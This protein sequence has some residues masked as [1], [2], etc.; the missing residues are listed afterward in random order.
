[1]DLMNTTG[2]RIHHFGRKSVVVPPAVSYQ[3]W[4]ETKSAWLCRF[5]TLSQLL[6][7]VLRIQGLPLLVVHNEGALL[8]VARPDGQLYILR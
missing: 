7:P 5:V 6:P 4:C 2:F 1:M 8:A 3:D